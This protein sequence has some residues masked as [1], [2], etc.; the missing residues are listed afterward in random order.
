MSQRE[1]EKLKVMGGLDRGQ[2]KQRD[3]AE[4]L[5]LS[6]C[7][8]RR[9]LR[10]YEREG[11]AGVVHRSR[12]Q[13]SPRKIADEVKHEALERVR[14]TYKGFAPTLA[15]EKLAERD[16]IEVSH[17]TLRQW[18]IEAELW[19]PRPRKLKHRQWR[20]R[21][22]CVGELVQMDTSEHQ[23]FEG[24][25]QE[26][27][28]IAMIDDATSRLS[29]RFFDTDSTRTNMIMIRDYIGKYGRPIAIYADKASHF[30]TTR[31]PSIEESLRDEQP[32]TQIARALRELDIRY[33]PAGSA[34][35]KGRV[36][37]AFGTMQDRLIKEM[38]LEGISTIAQANEFLNTKF[39]PFWN[40]SLIHI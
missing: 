40:L 16:G 15:A 39:I 28:L 14:N 8:V 32:A 1:R 18:M 20:E 26:A 29:A 10:R 2:L 9:I 21:K 7:Q 27:K 38:R 11:D 6:V 31:Q 5:A 12:G 19:S 22:A 13:P 30:K 25:G 36:E 34:Q 3:A 23:W 33:I 4:L 35:A 37:R 17:E 24:R